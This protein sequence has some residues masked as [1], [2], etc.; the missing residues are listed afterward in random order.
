MVVT[1]NASVRSD[2]T[3]ADHPVWNMAKEAIPPTFTAHIM[4]QNDT[5]KMRRFLR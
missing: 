4:C 5:M 2:W 1:K 3:R